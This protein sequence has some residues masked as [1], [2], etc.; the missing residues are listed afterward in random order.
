MATSSVLHA[1][2]RAHRLD[3][4]L[5]HVEEQLPLVGHLGLLARPS[6][7]G[8]RS[9]P[10]P[11]ERRYRAIA[12]GIISSPREGARSTRSIAVAGRRCALA[13]RLAPRAR[14]CP[15]VRRTARHV[16]GVLHV[17]TARV[18]RTLAAA[19]PTWRGPRARPASTSWSS[20]TTTRTTR[21]PAPATSTACWCSRGMEKSTDGGHAL[22][23]GREPAALPAR[24]RARDGA[25]GT[26]R[27]SVGSCSPPIRRRAAPRALD[28][29]L[30]GPRRPRG[31]L[32]RRRRLLAARAARRSWRRCAI[33][34]TR[35]GR[36]SQALR[37]SPR[38]ARAGT[39]ASRGA[40][41]AG[42]LG[43]DA[44]GGLRLGPLFVPAPSYRAVFRLGGNH[45]HAGRARERRRRARRGLVLARAARGP[46]LRGARRARRRAGFA[47]AATARRARRGT[48]RDALRSRPDERRPRAAAAPAPSTLV[49]LATAREV[50]RGETIDLDGGT[51]AGR[52]S[53][54]G[55]P[56]PASSGGRAR[57][58]SRTRSTSSARH[59]ARAR[60]ARR[61]VPPRAAVP[62]AGRDRSAST[63]A[64]RHRAGR[65]TVRRTRRA[66]SRL[67][68]GALRFDFALGPGPA[69]L[70]VG[71]RL[72]TARPLGAPR[73][74]RSAC[75]RTGRFRADVQ[76]RT[77]GRRRASSSG[78]APSCSIP[79]WRD[80]Y[81]PFAALRTSDRRGSAPGPRARGRRVLRGRAAAPRTGRAWHD[82]GR[83][84]GDGTVTRRS[85]RSPRPQDRACS[86]RARPRRA[87]SPACRCS[88]ATRVRSSWRTA[89]ARASRP[90]RAPPRS[91]AIRSTRCARSAAR[92]RRAPGRT[93]AAIAGVLAYDFARPGTRRG[94]DAA[95]L[96]ARGRPVPGGRRRRARR[97]A[98]RAASAD[99]RVR[100][101]ALDAAAPPGRPARAPTGLAA[102]S[103]LS[104][105]EHRALVLRVK[106]HVARRRHLPGEPVAALPAAVRGG[107]PRP[108]PR[109]CARAQP[110]AVLRLPARAAASRS[111]PPRPSACW[112]SRDGRLS[113]A[114]D[115]GHA[116]A[117]RRSGR[118]PRA[119]A[120]S[121]CSRRRSA[122]ST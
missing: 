111:C 31:R 98:R 27:T 60:A 101:R 120:P 22:V 6:P 107:R 2:A 80:V 17:H 10:A 20:P 81:V 40:P 99:P 18:R 61:A 50:A 119:R 69:H 8:G 14:G 15:P 114:A 112:R 83:R 53:R 47:F 63:R 109:S 82:L 52:L 97:D 34:S 90:R 67:E 59:E 86:S 118:R 103:S 122:P 4:P 7:R 68:A 25:C 88:R 105:D 73:A 91:P 19:S 104:R 39:P 36:C 58:S 92:S 121:C 72:G 74:S 95:A 35:A 84:L 113:H 110:R 102:W 44:H 38:R 66:P 65:S 55:V 29:G 115:R 77:G 64:A 9:G 87:R 75:A 23:L 79:A 3:H 30:R 48:G 89:R 46:R 96:R 106:E 11:A 5:G 108:L 85:T 78:G 49:L 43:S 94:P 41:A 100:R 32:P 28:G 76:V 42:W 117:R 57:G 24:R 37:P 93:R 16:R 56:R 33:R 71:L 13:H 45:L 70:R 1:N 62:P 116:A 12:A 26:R 54:G 51:R 21:S